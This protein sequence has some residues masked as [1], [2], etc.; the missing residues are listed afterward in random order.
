MRIFVEHM[1]AMCAL[2]PEPGAATTSSK[3]A[4]RS[5]SGIWA[6]L[7]VAAPVPTFCAVARSAA[8]CA[9]SAATSRSLR[10]SV[11]DFSLRPPPPS[12]NGVAATAAAAAA[13][14]NGSTRSPIDSGEPPAPC[15]NINA[16]RSAGERRAP[17]LLR[18]RGGMEPAASLAAARKVAAAAADVEAAA[19]ADDAAA[20]EDARTWAALVL[21]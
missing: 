14:S 4:G 10:C 13:P 7:P 1:A 8:Q 20:A 3:S 17:A 9:A 12:P 5:L 19:A 2:V 11:S 6:A 21:A 15:A 18:S 16:L